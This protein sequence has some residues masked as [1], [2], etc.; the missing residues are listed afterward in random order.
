MYENEIEILQISRARHA[1]GTEID[2]ALSAAIELM[3]AA[4]PKEEAAELGHCEREVEAISWTR[5]QVQD[6]LMRQ[7]AAAR[8]EC[9]IEL[10]F[11]RKDVAE[12][13]QRAEKA[14]R[15]EC[16][17]WV[18]KP[19]VTELETKLAAAQA[20]HADYVT[21][22]IADEQS[23]TALI[24]SLRA[25]LA[26]A[27]AEIADANAE[28]AKRQRAVEEWSTR[29]V[30]AERELTAAQAE[31][32]LLRKAPQVE[33]KIADEL[34]N[35]LAA[36]QAE[37]E[38]LRSDGLYIAL[39]DIAQGWQERAEKAERDNDSW[40]RVA[41]LDELQAQLAAAQAAIAEAGALVLSHE[42]HIDTLETK[43]TN[44][45]AAAERELARCE[46]CATYEADVFR[47]AI[48]ASKRP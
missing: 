17:K 35:K 46:C 47:A 45:R 25:Q 28:S 15:E 16:A 27:Q 31:I 34:S 19:G 39:N 40:R 5:A 44:L 4:Q 2:K 1:E 3:R 14:R 10:C 22:K 38:R 36:A 30:V 13:K 7:R 23:L 9:H 21:R 12:W 8:A 33:R 11:L 42:G 24:E 29:A 32:E 18:A 37:I 48:A 43:L 26:I 6:L 41:C 20:D